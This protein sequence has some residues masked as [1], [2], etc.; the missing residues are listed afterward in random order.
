MSE[1]QGEICP[2]C[3]VKIVGDKV[4]FSTGPIG[5]RSKLWARVCQ[6]TQNQ[7]CIN[8]N[9]DAIGQVKADDYYKPDTTS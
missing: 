7:A 6:F 8:Q 2:V 5:T 4:M 3:T 9:P 1:N